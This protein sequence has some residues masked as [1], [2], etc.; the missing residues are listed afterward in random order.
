MGVA[1]D[2]G[3]VPGG[4]DVA[5]PCELPATVRSL[6]GAQEGAVAVDDPRSRSLPRSLSR[7][8]Q[9]VDLVCLLLELRVTK[10]ASMRDHT[11][12]QSKNRCVSKQGRQ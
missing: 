11:S 12:K 7:V 4:V 5:G 6:V 9:L 3:H 2:P 10:A 1:N 8:V